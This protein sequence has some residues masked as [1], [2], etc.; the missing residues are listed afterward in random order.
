MYFLIEVEALG[1]ELGSIRSNCMDRRLDR[2]AFLSAGEQSE[3]IQAVG[4][5]LLQLNAGDPV[6][7]FLTQTANWNHLGRSYSTDV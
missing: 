7:A 6:T 1:L 4:L 5:L 2:R 3:V